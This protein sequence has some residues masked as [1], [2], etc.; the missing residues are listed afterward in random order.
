MPSVYSNLYIS[1]QLFLY[2][3]ISSHHSIT[4]KCFSLFTHW[5][6][7]PFVMCSLHIIF[8]WYYI[9]DARNVLELM[10]N[11]LWDMS[12]VLFYL[13]LF[14]PIKI[15]FLITCYNSHFQESKKY[16]L[17]PTNNVSLWILLTVSRWVSA[18]VTQYKAPL[19]L[20]SQS[21]LIPLYYIKR[22]LILHPVKEI[23]TPDTVIT[24]II[25]CIVRRG[26]QWDEIVSLSHSFQCGWACL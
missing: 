17:C 20:P 4:N 13:H 2:P 12:I 26:R 6:T 11:N 16:R 19:L 7:S 3:I 5:R 24:G 22:G 9:S 8:L 23:E 25:L 14:Y 1:L 10:E 18:I 15:A 21:K